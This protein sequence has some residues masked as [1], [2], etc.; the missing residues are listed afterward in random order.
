MTLESEDG[1]IYWQG[2][3]EE[4]GEKPVPVPLCPPQI[5]HGLTRAWTRASA[6]RDRRLPTWAMARPLVAWLVKTFS[7]LLWNSKVGCPVHKNPLLVPIL[8]Q[9]IQP[10]SSNYISWGPNLTL[11]SCVMLRLASGSSFSGLPTKMLYELLITPVRAICP[12]HPIYLDVI[13]LTV[14]IAYNV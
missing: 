11:F 4:L 10:L 5:P 1:M 13:V 3:T 9:R 6:V 14:F 2:K 12:A 7:P 8:N